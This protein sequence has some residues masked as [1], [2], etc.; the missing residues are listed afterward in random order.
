MG[1]SRRRKIII[2]LVILA[3]IALAAYFFLHKRRSSL[4]QPDDIK[5]VEVY[6]EMA[7]ARQA[8]GDDFNYLDSLYSVV[9]KKYDVDSAWLFNYAAKT[10]NSARKEKE[11]WDLIV[12]RLDSLRT[13]LDSD[14]SLYQ[15]SGSSSNAD[16]I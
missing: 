7:V 9:Y 5:F 16:S 6:T 13:A 8:A 14:S 12:E 4:L 11:I 2:L 1:V 3:A 10:S 15:S